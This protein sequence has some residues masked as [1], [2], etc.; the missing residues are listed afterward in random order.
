MKI[1]H[2]VFDHDGTLVDMDH[3]PVLY[4]NMEKLLNCLK[5][6]EIKIYVWTARE[7]HS[8]IKILKSL[9]ILPIFEDIS[10]ATDC[11]PKPDPQGLMDMFQ[12]EEVDP[13]AVIHVGDSSTDIVG[14]KKFGA[15]TIGAIWD[16]PS[17]D[18][19]KYLESY[20]ADHIVESV[21]ECEELILELIK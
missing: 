9:D 19:R 8:T 20:G 16:D 1:K 21:A 12:F 18:H 5:D 7:R 13:R 14:G 10:T 4:P 3:G 6:K 2:V 17:L 11:Y 15:T